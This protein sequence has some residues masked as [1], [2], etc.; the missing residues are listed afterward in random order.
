MNKEISNALCKGN[1][2]TVKKLCRKNKVARKLAVLV[3]EA[4]WAIGKKKIAAMTMRQ[5]RLA[6]YASKACASLQVGEYQGR[7]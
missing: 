1:Y 6:T 7:W 5:K 4:S 3:A 2:D